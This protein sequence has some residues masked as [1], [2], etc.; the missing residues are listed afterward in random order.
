MKNRFIPSKIIII[1]ADHTNGCFTPKVTSKEGPNVKKLSAEA[2]CNPCRGFCITMDNIPVIKIMNMQ[3]RR[4]SKINILC[5]VEN[6]MRLV[7]CMKTYWM[8]F[9]LS[10]VN[11]DDITSITSEIR[12]A[13]ILF[14]MNIDSVRIGVDNKD[15]K[16]LYTFSPPIEYEIIFTVIR[17]TPRAIMM[18]G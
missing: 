4:L 1:P 10:Q 9:A 18:I 14:P 12:I 3:I 16:V 7:S 6:Q 2:I 11:N 5:A 13:I 15:S 17:G 8:K